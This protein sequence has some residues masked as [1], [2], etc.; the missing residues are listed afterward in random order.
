MDESKMVLKYVPIFSELDDQLLMKVEDAGILRNYKED[1]IILDQSYEGTG[2]YIIIDGKV[3]VTENDSDG[4]E[5]ILQ[6]LGEH[7]FFGEMSLI[8][9]KKPSANVIAMEDTEL[10]FLSREE[11][12]QLMHS[13]PEITIA[14]LEE[15]TRRLRFAGIRIKSLSLLNSEERLPPQYCRLLKTWEK[16]NRVRLKCCSLSSMI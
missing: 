8:D 15:F 3:K 7:E 1:M 2:L 11:F 13:T 14:L 10:F 16:L 6:I 12:L 5:I 4:R 9:G